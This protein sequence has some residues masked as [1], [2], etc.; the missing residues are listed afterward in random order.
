MKIS[1][2]VAVNKNNG[3]GLNGDLPWRCPADMK[4]F[5][6]FTTGKTV[7]MGRKTFESIS[8]PLPNRVNIILT[9]D[10]SFKT[11]GA[12]VAHTVEEVLKLAKNELVVIG[13][14]EIYNLFKP[15]IHDWRVTTVDDDSECDTFLNIS[16]SGFV[17]MD[18]QHG[19]SNDLGYQIS[20]FW[21]K[22]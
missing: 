13:G 2:I 3:I 5:K 11:K 7:V 12:E 10:L 8:R 17:R 20:K 1:A 16:F 21:R 22:L 18:L 19:T 4:Y 6:E 14:S 15:F 9:R